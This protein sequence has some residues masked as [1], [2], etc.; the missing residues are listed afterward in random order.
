M[1]WQCSFKT[2]IGKAVFH[3]EL[4]TKKL[5][6]E[7]DI[8]Q[9]RSELL[10]DGVPGN[11]RASARRYS[12]LP[13]LPNP[14]LVWQNLSLHFGKPTIQ[15]QFMKAQK[16]IRAYDICLVPAEM[17]VS[18]LFPSALPCA[19]EILAPTRWWGDSSPPLLPVCRQAWAAQGRSALQGLGNASISCWPPGNFTNPLWRRQWKNHLLP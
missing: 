6:P 3:T 7:E 1:T 10:E 2:T 15:A 14:K 11:R 19:R 9:C 12:H 8:W 13:S 16:L 18:N 4:K 5:L 17:L